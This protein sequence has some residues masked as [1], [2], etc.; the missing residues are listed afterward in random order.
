MG[1]SSKRASRASRDTHAAIRQHAARL[2]AA[3]VSGLRRTQAIPEVD[4]LLR[5]CQVAVEEAVPAAVV[6]EGRRY[7]LRVRMSLQ[8]D[9]FDTPGD[10]EPLIRGV[11]FSSEGFGHVPGH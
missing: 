1:K 9:V 11:T 3:P 5:A 6:F 10:A 2:K 4:A 8:L 7:F